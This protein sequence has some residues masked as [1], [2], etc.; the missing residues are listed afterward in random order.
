MTEMDYS[1]LQVFFALIHF[2]HYAV[3]HHPA[4]AMLDDSFPC[5]CCNVAGSSI[6]AQSSYRLLPFS[7]VFLGAGI[8]CQLIPLPTALSV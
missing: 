8:T 7:I 3:A 6:A 1:F 5:C 4:V 2:G